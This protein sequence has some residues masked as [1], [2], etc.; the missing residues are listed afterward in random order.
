MDNGDRLGKVPLATAANSEPRLAFLALM[1]LATA[2]VV[3]FVMWWVGSSFYDRFDMLRTDRPSWDVWSALRAPTQLAAFAVTI[4][5]GVRWRRAVAT[6]TVATVLLVAAAVLAYGRV[7]HE[8]DRARAGVPVAS[9]VWLPFRFS[10]RAV[11]LLAY[12]GVLPAGISARVLLL[13]DG[14]G[15]NVV[16]DPASRQT[17]RVDDRIATWSSSYG[18]TRWGR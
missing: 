6:A 13:R 5:V 2:L 4:A 7:Q 10:A 9:S 11:T 1:W 16:Y 15:T 8:A 18:G 14:S 17:M 12:D 3:S